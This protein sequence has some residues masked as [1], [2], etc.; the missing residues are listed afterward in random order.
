[1]CG[2]RGGGGGGS[3]VCILSIVYKPTFGMACC[4]DA[5]SFVAGGAVDK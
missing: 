5:T 4:N 1:M 3:K 2:G